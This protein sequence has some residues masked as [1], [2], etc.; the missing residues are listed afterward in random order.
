[1]LRHLPSYNKLKKRRYLQEQ[2]SQNTIRNRV[3]EKQEAFESFAFEPET[4]LFQTDSTPEEPV[5]DKARELDQFYTRPEV[6]ALCM[7]RVY[8]ILPI[9]EIKLWIEPSAGT[10]IFYN[11]LPHPRRGFDVDADHAGDGIEIRDFLTW[12]YHGVPRGT[13]TVGNP[14]FG[15]N[16]SLALQFIKRACKYSDWICMIL[17]RTFEKESMQ[18]KIPQNF[19]LVE[20]SFFVLEPYSFMHN[21]EPYDVPCC[22]QIW[23]K[24]P[25]GQMRGVIR[26]IRNHPD[27]DF[28]S[29][30]EDAD[31]AFQRVGGNAG[32]ASK[33]GLARSWKSNH[34]IKAAQGVDWKAL[35]DDF[36][37]INW[38]EIGQKTAGNPSIG[39]G[40]MIAELSKIRPPRKIKSDKEMDLLDQMF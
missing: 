1:M 27:F 5:R 28:V 35:M 24:L 10:G 15:K 39:K 14:P 32:L 23:K 18:N 36:N 38:K 17:P 37:R 2:G 12:D 40:E 22:F 26:Q 6:A 25:A 11:L 30:P 31:F 21:N 8:E 4:G 3:L 19:E 34:F 33:E 20:E 7:E 29:K 9:D 13:A 16:S